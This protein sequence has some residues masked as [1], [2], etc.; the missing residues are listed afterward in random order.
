MS[1]W[2]ITTHISPTGDKHHYLTVHKGK[3]WL[4]SVQGESNQL[5]HETER[6]RN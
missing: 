3:S 2:S 1:K 5:N 4:Y 6:K